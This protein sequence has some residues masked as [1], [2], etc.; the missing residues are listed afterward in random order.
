VDSRKLDLLFETF[1]DITSLV[2]TERGE[3]ALYSRVL[4]CCRDLLHTDLVMLLRVRNRRLERYTKRGSGA[5]LYRDEITATP[6]LLDWLE[7]EATPFMGPAGEWRLP[8]PD[9]LFERHSGSLL[10]V[11]LVAKERQLGLLVSMREY[12]RDAFGP[13]DLKILNV[14]ANQTAIALE[15]ADLYERLRREALTDG[16]TGILNY[17]S[18]MRALRSELR[19]AERYSQTFAFVMADVDHLKKYNESF[20]HLAGSQVLV[21]VARLMVRGCRSTDVVGKYGGDEFAIILPQTDA[22]GACT[23]SER[24]RRAIG[25]HSFQHVQPGD[26]TCSFGVAVFPR[27]GGDVFALIRQADDVLFHAKRSGRNVVRTSADLAAAAPRLELAG[28]A[29]AAPDAA[30]PPLRLARR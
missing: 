27:D 15:N 19:R 3:A 17:R 10:C 2:R 16:L 23:V 26:V 6:A 12:V 5:A 21:Q 28:G 20:G 13:A 30:P 18:F 8:F 29:P 11:P 1:F 4:D 24:I 22:E 9:R 7:R 14:L 25:Q